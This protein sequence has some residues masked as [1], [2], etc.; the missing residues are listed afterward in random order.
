MAR[1]TGNLKAKQVEKLLRAGK[2]GRHYDG[3][4]LRLEI[5]SKKAAAWVARYQIDGTEHWMG[6]GSARVFTL[7]EAR[8]RNRKLVRQKIADGIDPLRVR[9]ADRNAA[10]AAA[11][12]AMTFDEAA[13]RFLE[14]HGGKWENAQHKA[15]WQNTLR[16]YAGPVIGKM[17]VADIDVAL[18]L[19]VLEQPV[20]ADRGRPAGPMWTV[21]AETASRLRGRIEAILDWAKVRGY[22]SGDNPASW[23]L[24]GKA[25]PAR[26]GG[27][28]HGAMRYADVP[29]FM[30]KLREQD[31]I[32]AKALQFTILT[33]AR[34][35]EV[36]GAVW[37]EIDLAEAVWV[38]PASR[39]KARKE[40]RVPL[41]AEA[42]AL[43]RDL[44]TEAGNKFVFI[45]RSAGQPLGR[46][47]MAQTLDR[48][49]SG[50]VHG[51]RASF[52]TWSSES[53][54]FPHDVAEAALAHVRGDQTVQAYSRGDLLDKRRKLMEA[55]AKFCSSP[56]V[57][58][59]SGVVPLRPE[60]QP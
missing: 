38:V 55:W 3:L 30:A 12:K 8:E 48:M 11:A 40:H 14:Q 10:R 51:F 5:R 7:T 46:G 18:V 49:G 31:S 35:G 39:M 56:P 33:A 9:Q 50:T 34:S 25:L 27:R 1:E 22:R 21:R 54:A 52:R 60:R 47:S 13:K 28:H 23:S 16:D 42:V 44:P 17:P 57:K 6:L 32:A 29:A 2:P 20:A 37:G 45:G 41:S 24:I 36:L 53:T 19:K 43:L 4:G 58:K 59:A 26:T 15:Q